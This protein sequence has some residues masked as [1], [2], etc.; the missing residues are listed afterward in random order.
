ML[1][2]RRV[3][4]VCMHM[5]SPSSLCA[6]VPARLRP[7]GWKK[8]HVPRSRAGTAASSTIPDED[9]GRSKPTAPAPAGGGGA[10]RSLSLTDANTSRVERGDAGETSYCM[11]ETR[12]GLHLFGLPPA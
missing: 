8:A 4:P 6:T 10:R 2:D 3:D 11:S 9:A 7:S 12:A 1:L 5:G